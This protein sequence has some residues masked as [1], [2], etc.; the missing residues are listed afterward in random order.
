MNELPS[1][2]LPPELDELGQR[3]S[4]ERPVA[5]DPALDRVMTRAQSARRPRKSLLWRSSAPRA[6]RKSVAALVAGVMAM[7]GVT[8][9]AV[10]GASADSN[11]NPTALNS[12]VTPVTPCP[13][14]T[15]R[16]DLP[17]LL[18]AVVVPD[19]NGVCP[20]GTI[21]IEIPTLLCLVVVPDPGGTGGGGTGGGGTTTACPQGTIRISSDPLI[22]VTALLQPVDGVCPTG[23]IRVDLGGVACV[24]LGTQ[25]TGGGTLPAVPTNV[26]QGALDG[27]GVGSIFR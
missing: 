11:V 1:D 24:V 18:C 25:N 15:V 10:L 23:S 20:Q 12:P 16:V 7:A 5:S 2:N 14:G 21:R 17:G 9:V 6:G 27:L 22:C 19:V 8:G 4:K 3:M 13:Q 26:L